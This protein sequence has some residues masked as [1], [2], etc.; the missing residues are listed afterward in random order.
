VGAGS[1][2]PD[3]DSRLSRSVTSFGTYGRGIIDDYGQLG[4]LRSTVT[5]YDSFN[6]TVQTAKYSA[7][8]TIPL[9]IPPEGAG[10]FVGVEDVT[11]DVEPASIPDA[12]KAPEIDK[13]DGAIDPYRK[14]D[15]QTRGDE[16]TGILNYALDLVWANSIGRIRGVNLPNPFGVDPYNGADVE[17][18]YWNQNR[19]GAFSVTWDA[20]ETGGEVILAPGVAILAVDFELDFERGGADRGAV[21]GYYNYDVEFEARVSGG[22]ETQSVSTVHS[23]EFSVGG[24]GGGGGGGGGGGCRPSDPFCL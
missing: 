15:T 16:N 3:Q 4:Q 24:D 21:N 8:C 14:G 18:R 12:S 17:S 7:V 23:L 10:P 2:D 13:R 9:G 1:A 22:S 11:I 6:S 5:G 19:H 20:V